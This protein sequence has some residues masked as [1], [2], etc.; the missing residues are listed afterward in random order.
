MMILPLATIPGSALL[1]ALAAVCEIGGGN[2]IWQWLRN[3]RSVALGAL[4][5]GL[6]CLLGVGVIMYTPRP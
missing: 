1:F 3:G 5:G 2:L 6:L 4:G